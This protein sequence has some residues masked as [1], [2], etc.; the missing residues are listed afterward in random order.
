MAGGE[1]LA[2]LPPAVVATDTP[3][4]RAASLRTNA[5][6]SLRSQWVCAWSGRVVSQAWVSA[7]RSLSARMFARV[8]KSP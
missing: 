6:A 1:P 5:A 4:S 7:R 2:T 8:C 3:L